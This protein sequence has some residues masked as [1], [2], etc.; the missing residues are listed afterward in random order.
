LVS[1]VL[2]N[3]QGSLI[4]E[5]LVVIACR[6]L[7]WLKSV[8]CCFGFGVLFCL[9]FISERFLK[10]R[11]R[12]WKGEVPQIYSDCQVPLRALVSI[13][14]WGYQEKSARSDP[15]SQQKVSTVWQEASVNPTGVGAPVSHLS[16]H[17]LTLDFNITFLCYLNTALCLMPGQRLS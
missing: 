6:E 14:H 7:P 17:W 16:P 1:Y 5:P 8:C 15:W 3:T 13:G 11:P 12:K 10:I 2:S 4:L 9:Y